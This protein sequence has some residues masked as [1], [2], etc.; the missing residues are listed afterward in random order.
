MEGVTR[1][2][3]PPSDVTVCNHRKK[4]ATMQPVRAARLGHRYDKYIHC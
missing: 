3:P 4:P 1:G 2:G